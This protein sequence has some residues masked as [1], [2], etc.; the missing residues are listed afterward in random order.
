[1]RTT[2]ANVREQSFL[3]KK[4]YTGKKYLIPYDAAQ[5]IAFALANDQGAESYWRWWRGE[6]TIPEQLKHAWLPPKSDWVDL[7]LGTDPEWIIGWLDG[8]LNENYDHCTIFDKYETGD[9]ESRLK[10]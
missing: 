7:F 4:E 10:R 9:E 3:C 8:E 5:E 1:M 2:T 6:S